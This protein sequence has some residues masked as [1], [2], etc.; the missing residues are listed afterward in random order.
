MSTHVISKVQH[1]V[2]SGEIKAL[3]SLGNTTY[4]HISSLGTSISTPSHFISAR[5]CECVWVDEQHCH[6]FL[7]SES[8][9]VIWWVVWVLWEDY[10]LICPGRLPQ[11]NRRINRCLS[12]M[13][14]V[15]NGN[16]DTRL[17]NQ[18]VGRKKNESQCHSIGV[19]RIPPPERRHIK[20]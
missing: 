16:T 13:L 12:V 5:V 11:Q 14:E 10:P 3:V 17:C 18:A 15:I 20:E 1:F 19:N 8:I 6:E 9:P 2:A 4:R 7:L